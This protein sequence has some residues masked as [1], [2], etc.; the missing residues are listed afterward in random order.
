[1][2]KKKPVVITET[3]VADC[4]PQAPVPVLPPGQESDHAYELY[5]EHQKQTW[6]DCQSASDEFDKSVLT[7]SS[8]GLGVSLAFI[9]D[10]VPLARAVA[11]P[12]LYGSWIAFGVTILI[13]IGSYWLSIHAQRTHLEHL[14]KYYLDKQPEYLNARNRAASWVGAFRWISGVCFL[15]A[16]AGTIVF[17]ILNVA[18]S[19]TMS[20]Q[21]NASVPVNLH[22]GR[23]PVSMT[24][25]GKGLQ[26][27]AMTPVPSSAVQQQTPAASQAATPPPANQGQKN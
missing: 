15:L 13:T 5:V 25:L 12:L 20:H 10:I 8:A 4:A 3:T 27:M 16:I 2:K 23:Q 7:Y 19:R 22:E 9:K 26:P 6:A 1:M 11:L 21:K 18:E 17:S 24:P 14:R